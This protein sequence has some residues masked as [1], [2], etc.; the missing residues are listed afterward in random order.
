MPTW[1]HSPPPTSGPRPPPPHWE[2]EHTLS[3]GGR[4]A[5]KPLRGFLQT[6]P[7]FFPLAGL[8]VHPLL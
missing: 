5:M 7:V 1:L 3:L 8:V 4:E 6:V 2:K